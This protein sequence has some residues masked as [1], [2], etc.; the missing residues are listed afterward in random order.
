MNREKD[1]LLTA[2]GL[3][4][5]YLNGEN[6]V[7]ALKE[8]NITLHKGEAVSVFGPSGSGKST[9]LHLL[10]AFDRP[11]AGKV[12]FDGQDI[13]TFPD[14]ELAHFRNREIGFVFQFHH[15]L[16]E[17]STLE[18]VALPLYISGMKRVEAEE[19]AAA[20]LTEVGLKERLDF[21]PSKLSG[22]EK[23]RVAVARALVHE[24]RLLLADEPTGN[25]DAET[26]KN[27]M[28][29]I[30]RLNRKH[31]ATMVVVSHDAMIKKYTDKRYNLIDGRL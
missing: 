9:L 2:T 30:A 19:K 27:V 28:E 24:P 17:F 20:Y 8:A 14:E 22:G 18:N 5:T 15:L 7:E 13:F 6:K 1:I 3:K 23:Q 16:P 11:T 4:R 31:Q 10:G 21:L 12:V 29:M 25:L 26:S